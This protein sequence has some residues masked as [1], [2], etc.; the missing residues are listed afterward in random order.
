MGAYVGETWWEFLRDGGEIFIEWRNKK[1]KV[2]TPFIFTN[3]FIGSQAKETWSV[4]DV[5]L[6]WDRNP[7]AKVKELVITY[8]K[9]IIPEELRGIAIQRRGMKICNF[10]IRTGN[11]SIKTDIAE[12]L[13]GWITFN[14]EA[15]AEL[16]AIEDPTHYDFSAYVGTF[17]YHVFG[18]AG[19]LA[20]EVRK[21]AEQK[22]GLG[23]KA[24]KPDR[25]DIL[26]IN[27]LNRF[28]NKY[29]LGSPLNRTSPG[30]GP[31]PGPRNRKEI[32]IKM[33]KPSFP[34]DITRRVEFG[35]TIQ[36]IKV[37]VVNDS[38]RSVKA[39]LSL[40]LKTASRTIK[41][42]IL[43][44]FVNGKTI[45]VPSK[46]ESITFGP[47]SVTFS[48]RKFVTGTY[49]IEAEIALLEGDI[50]DDQFGKAVIVD[51]D[52]ELVYLDENPP[53]GRGLFEF[54]D[55]VEFK[56]ERDL[57]FRV[58]EKDGKMRI[59]IN[60]LHP[61]YKHNEVLDDLLEEKKL[62][63]SRKLHRPLLDYEINIGAEVIAQYDV[64]K[65]AKLIK[66]DCKE[67]FILHR[68]EDKNA[69]F[70]DA[71]DQASRIAQ[72]IRYEVL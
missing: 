2:E 11:P 28:A 34:R 22:L 31:G 64:R 35:E 14:K 41:E 13:Y 27:R 4:T 44:R 43:E 42:R 29:K 6:D 58:K 72:R 53:T 62:Y 57:Q 23:L 17:G 40:V 10:S 26:V 56:D 67:K 69:F 36:N 51:Q 1:V 46:S 60:I 16:R 49:V 45:V 65:E 71:I 7:N 5:S 30:P 66:K 12:Y 38:K 68:G 21:F 59:Q 9:R 47:Y 70:V 50:L 32:R 39:K 24:R 3:G 25:L 19:W 20:Q 54:I 8:S 48:K 37:S 33:T 52:R 63:I 15:E 18:K 61:A 55:R